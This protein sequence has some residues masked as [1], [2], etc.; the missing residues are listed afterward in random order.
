MKAC[1]GDMNAG[2]IKWVLEI[3]CKG[4]ETHVTLMIR[5]L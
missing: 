1:T 4:T 3:P 5:H 2:A